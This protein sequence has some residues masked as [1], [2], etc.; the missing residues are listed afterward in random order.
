MTLCPASNISRSPRNAIR[1]WQFPAAPSD[2][3]VFGLAFAI[4]AGRGSVLPSWRMFQEV[5]FFWVGDFS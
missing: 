1:T 3:M 2:T 5:G 4:A